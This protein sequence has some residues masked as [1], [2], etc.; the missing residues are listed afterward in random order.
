MTVRRRTDAV[1]MR[2]RVPEAQRRLYRAYQERELER[3][4]SVVAGKK[5][6]I[7]I[8]ST[9]PTGLGLEAKLLERSPALFEDYT[10]VAEEGMFRIWRRTDALTDAPTDVLGAQ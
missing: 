8:Q 5:P 6:E 10:I 2:Q 3:T 9:T 7:I 1:M 4:A